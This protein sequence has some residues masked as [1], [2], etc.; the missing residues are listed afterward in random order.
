[1]ALIR[2]GRELGGR[3]ATEVLLSV[4]GSEIAEQLA[5]QSLQD[6]DWREKL[7]AEIRREKEKA[8]TA[9][10]RAQRFMKFFNARSRE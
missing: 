7:Q 2:L 1:M 9:Q 6:K 4:P 5:F 10:E 8:M 3:T